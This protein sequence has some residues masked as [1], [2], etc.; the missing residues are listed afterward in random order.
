[1]PTSPPLPHPSRCDPRREDY[2]AILLAHAEA[3]SSGQT[4]YR[5]PSTGLTVLT[6]ATHLARGTCC[7]SGCRHCPYL[8]E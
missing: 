3:V 2:Q 4:S 7:E 5:D 1:M 8:E 6:V